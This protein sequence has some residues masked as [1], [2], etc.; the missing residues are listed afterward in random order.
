MVKPASFP[1][2][3]GSLACLALLLAGQSVFAQ[4][5]PAAAAKT[6]S[7]EAVFIPVEYLP[8]PYQISVGVRISGNAK[9]KF[10][11]LGSIASNV[12]PGGDK[13]TVANRTYNDGTVALDSS[14]DIDGNQI[15]IT[16]GKTNYWSFTSAD[17]VVEHPTLGKS[18]ALHAYAVT[19]RG[20]TAE[21]ENSSSTGW[22]LQISRELGSGRIMSWGILFGAGIN[23]INCKTDGTIKANLR[24]LT[25]YYS[26][27]GVTLG[28]DLSS[29]AGAVGVFEYYRTQLVKD[30]DGKVVTDEN[31][32]NKWEYVLVDGK[33]TTAWTTAERLPNVPGDRTDTINTDSPIDVAGYWQ[34]KGAYITARFG[35][36]VSLKLGRHFAFRASAG[37]T[38]T[39][40]GAE[41]IIHEK[42]LIPS[43]TTYLEV[44]NEEVNNDPMVTGTIGYF[45]SGEFEAFLT[46]RTGFFIGATHED[47]A[48]DIKLGY[49]GY[50]QT[51]DL[52]VS[53]GT[54]IRTGITTRF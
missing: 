22:D 31:G 38:F 3:S 36:F 12:F 6:E 41:L 37:I 53:S 23:S 49:Y 47:Y 42:F 44:N 8:P 50:N 14:I 9:V 28:A 18:A 25:D 45:A 54:A 40:L 34:V 10:S 48:R 13:T 27:A 24:T 19:S 35:P 46:N 4:S 16:D 11:G 26:L 17:Q 43:L 29:G 2:Y 51:A 21:A 30:A 20:A 5:K 15:E 52:S 39:V 1:R 33:K 32:Y 7:E